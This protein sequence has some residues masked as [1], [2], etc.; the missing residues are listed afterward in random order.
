M[1]DR[2]T[3]IWRVEYEAALG[4]PEPEVRRK[5]YRHC[6]SAEAAG[7][8]IANIRAMPTHLALDGVVVTSAPIE[9]EPVDPETLPIPDHDPEGEVDWQ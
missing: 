7:R 1:S 3:R 6:F 2:P 4:F 8:Q 9:W 5:T